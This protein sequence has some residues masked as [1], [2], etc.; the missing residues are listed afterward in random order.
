[1]SRGEQAYQT[2]K[3]RTLGLALGFV[4]LVGVA[5]VTVLL[6]EL[7]NEPDAEEQGTDAMSEDLETEAAL[8][9]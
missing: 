5:V 3:W 2:A 7:A 6:P 4:M 9:E 1:M 8:Q